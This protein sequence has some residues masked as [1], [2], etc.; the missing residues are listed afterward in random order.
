MSIPGSDGMWN[1]FLRLFQDE[2]QFTRLK[3]VTV[4]MDLTD[5]L[6]STH[7]TIFKSMLNVKN[8]ALLFYNS[9]TGF[10]LPHSR[11]EII[12][13]QLRFLS[14]TIT[15]LVITIRDETSSND[16]SD[17]L[18]RIPVLPQLYDAHFG[19]ARPLQH[20]VLQ[21]SLRQLSLLGLQL[22]D[23]RTQLR[24]IE[25]L[26]LTSNITLVHYN[27]DNPF[28]GSKSTVLDTL[29]QLLD[30][31]NQLQVVKLRL[32]IVDASF[33]SHPEAGR[34]D[35][36][37]QLCLDRLKQLILFIS[38]PYDNHLSLHASRLRNYLSKQFAPEVAAK[39]KVIVERN[40]S[41]AAP[42]PPEL[43]GYAMNSGV[44]GNYVNLFVNPAPRPRQA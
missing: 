26:V 10:P 29:T 6:N 27:R 38:T 7:E 17:I 30:G 16:Y 3:T 31:P 8:L 14:Q 23:N 9:H 5:W 39:I 43:V 35:Q 44:V 11:R 13:Q 21:P 15:R 18:Q 1:P 41:I 24:T 2:S 28:F 32:H 40:A 12:T 37:S 19:V 22:D 25:Q 33:R 34:T 36:I 20:L 42:F 4:K